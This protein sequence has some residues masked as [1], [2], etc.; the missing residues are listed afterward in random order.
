MVCHVP[1]QKA[2]WSDQTQLFMVGGCTNTPQT[3]R[4]T[5]ARLSLPSVSVTF[6]NLKG[7]LL[8]CLLMFILFFF[9]ALGSAGQLT[10]RLPRGDHSLKAQLE[11]AGL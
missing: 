6:I 4:T 3:T 5:K 2:V 11:W 9:C 8:H 1:T 10:N 7:W